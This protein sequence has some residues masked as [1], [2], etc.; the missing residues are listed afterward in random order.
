MYDIFELIADD[1]NAMVEQIARENNIQGFFDS[2]KTKT[3]SLVDM[4]KKYILLVLNHIKTRELFRQ[5]KKNN[6]VKVTYCVNPDF[7]KL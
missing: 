6:D 3:N 5:Y 2:E 7:E 4:N 1:L